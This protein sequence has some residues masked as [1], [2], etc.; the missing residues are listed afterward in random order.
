MEAAGVASTIGYFNADDDLPE[1][2]QRESCS[3]IDAIAE[4]GMSGYASIKVPSLA[5][6]M[7]RVRAIADRARRYGQLLHFDSHG[8]QTADPTLAVLGSLL[9]YYPKLGLTIPGRWLRSPDDADWATERNI[10]VRVVKGQWECSVRPDIDPREGFL[11]VI[12]RLAGRAAEV[13]IATHD[14]PLAHAAIGRL[15][16]TGTACELELLSGLPRR[17][18]MTVAR[19]FGIPVRLYIPFGNAWLPYALGQVLRKPRMWGWMIRDV[20]SAVIAH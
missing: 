13:A 8:P 17:E 3:A 5:Y 9:P 14:A 16:K 7:D 6:S 12:D 1:T 18:V 10:R 19:E 20:M 2:V 15:M 4:L 11:A